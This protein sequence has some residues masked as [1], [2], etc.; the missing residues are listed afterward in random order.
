MA[1]VSLSSSKAQPYAIAGDFNG[2]NNNGTINPGGGPTVYTN[3]MSGGTPGTFQG[4]K[5]IAVPGSWSVTYPSGNLEISYDANGSNTVYLYPG[6]F[7]DGW[8]PLQNRVGFIDPGNMSFEIAGDFTSPNWGSDPAAG[9]VLQGNGVYTNTYIVATP[10]T[11]AFKI[12]STGTWSH[13]NCGTD[14]GGGNPS[15]GSFTTTNANQPVQFQLDLPNGRW[16]AG[17]AAPAPVT[18]EV[19]FAVDMTYQIQLG[20]FTPGS[21]VFVAGDFNSWPAPS[22]GTGLALTNYPPYQGGGNTNIYYGTNTFV[23]IPSTSPSQYKFNQNDP[24][25]QNGGWESSNNRNVTLLSKNG[26]NALPVAV[27]SD[28]YPAENLTAPAAVFF[29]IDMSGAVGTDAHTFNPSADSVYING[30]FANWY[31]WAGGINPSPAPGGYQMFE[32]GLST[33][34]TNTIILP[35]GTPLAFQY[36]YGMDPG[37]ANSGPLDDEA[38]SYVNHVRVVRSTAASPYVL[39]TDKFGGMYSEPYFSATSTGGGNLA[40]GAIAGS[41]VPVSWLGRPGAHLQANTNLVGGTWI[42]MPE[43]DGANWTAGYNSTNG[44]VSVTNLPVA[45]RAYFRLVKP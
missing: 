15:N 34:Y 38:A 21:S 22:T 13:F 31:A 14:F 45:G 37:S 2:W 6:S 32:E 3:I 29:S 39:A 12:R 16:L 18:N 33:I 1:V 9:M 35:A 27:F 17:S 24:N 11:H 41:K 23:G 42:D 4:V 40:V 20:Y 36:K 30:V 28:V 10:G 26:T 8:L 7:S 44:L 19:V 43:T 5:F 25:A